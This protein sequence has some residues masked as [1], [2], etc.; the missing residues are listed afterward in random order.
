[1]FKSILNETMS[2]VYINREVAQIG[3][4]NWCDGDILSLMEQTQLVNHYWL[5]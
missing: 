5:P 1:M 2:T 4:S 3:C